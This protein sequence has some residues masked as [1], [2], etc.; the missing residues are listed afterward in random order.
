M[1]K[2][3]QFFLLNC[4]CLLAYLLGAYLGQLLL[5]P[6]NGASPI[7]P[8]AG[9]ALGAFFLY[10]RYAFPGIFLGSI[11]T[12][13]PFNLGNF[14]L[15]G[16]INSLPSSLFISIGVCLQ[17]LLSVYLIRQLVG[18]DDLLIKDSKIL[19][20]LLISSII[21]SSIAPIFFSIELLYRKGGIISF[22]DL[23]SSWATWWV[24]D[25]IGILIVTPLILIFFAKPRSLWRK[26]RNYVFYPLLMLLVLSIIIL[27]YSQDQERKRVKFVFDRQSNILD[28]ALYNRLNTFLNVN[29]FLKGFAENSDFVNKDSFQAF[30]ST[31]FQ[32]YQTIDS[33]EWIS[34]IK[35]SQRVQFEALS[36]N[37]ILEIDRNKPQKMKVAGERKEYFPI[38]YIV[39]ENKTKLRGFDL[40]SKDSILRTLRKAWESKQI[41]ATENLSLVD[42]IEGSENIR[43]YSAVFQLSKEEKEEKEEEDPELKG[44]VINSFNIKNEIDYLMKQNDKLQVDV[45][46]LLGNTLIYSSFPPQK[47]VASA[48]LYRKSVM[49]FANHKWKMTYR[50]SKHFNAKQKS[51]SQWWLLLGSFLFTGLTGVALLMLSGRTLRTEDLVKQ[52]TKALSKAITA[53]DQHNKVLQSIAS[54]TPLNEILTLVVESTEE[55]N[56]GLLCS[57]LLLNEA[58]DRLVYGASGKLPAF[59]MKE[60]E[61]IEIGEA[62]I[63]CGSAAYLKHRVIVPDISKHPYWKHYSDLAE[64]AHLGACW[65]EPLMSSGREVLGTFTLYYKEPKIPDAETLDKIHALSQLISLAIEKKTSEKRIRYLAFYDALTNLPNRRLLHERLDQ[66]LVLV[67][68]HRNYGALLFLDLDHFKILN[69]SLGHHIGDEL[70][71]QVAERLK[72]CVREE[73][74]VARL[75]GDEFVVLL[76]SRDSNENSEQT[77]DYASMIAKR[78]L[79]SLHIP[80]A[81]EKYEHVVTSSIGITLFGLDNKNRDTLFKQADTA[82]YEAKNQ[83]RNTFSFY[84][85]NMAEK[86]NKRLQMEKDIRA[87]L[88]NKEFILH[89]Q[90]QYND[91]NIIIGAEALLRWSHPTRGMIAVRDFMPTCEESGIIL[92]IAEWELRTIC[93][94]LLDCPTLP[95]VALNISSRQ[96][97]QQQFILQI[98]QILEEYHLP[99]NRLMIEI[100]ERIVV[101]DISVSIEKLNSL[102]AL[103]IQISIDDFGVGYSSLADLKNLPIDQLKIDRSFINDICID[104]NV[105][106]IVEAMLMMATHLGL[107]VIA[108]GVENKGQLKFLQANQCYLYQGYY[109]S[110]P[111]PAEEFLKLLGNPKKSF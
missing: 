99:S 68:R 85:T 69:D 107:D 5:L 27:N 61:G 81:L 58:G 34:Y 104:S 57:I 70:L 19:K 39:P 41:V 102:R 31:I 94:Q 105:A 74:T 98:Q 6:P 66:E 88:E 28:D 111:L 3:K 1:L 67:E 96:F 56:P 51:W 86:A 110:K 79:K 30:S 72:E 80:Y 100:T 32:Q 14:S 75:G 20:F 15:V 10:G 92:A 76:R 95:H 54:Y 103:G 25:A 97:Y 37:K 62:V 43:I 49:D 16:M 29:L 38:T 55:D 33:I 13:V 73:D 83:G 45:E 9:I 22:Y 11:L 60:I 46:I 23:L 53:R 44:F 71:I 21:G 2:T 4:A 50:P 84:T 87:A 7:W 63:T 65:T 59:F 8:P 101:Q 52:R 82:M 77:L 42:Y 40:G 89:Y 12:H 36:G 18:R 109:F 64:R 17:A 24:G 91:Q 90:A 35:D 93:Q 106:L 47:L 108:E 48:H 26:R 78:I